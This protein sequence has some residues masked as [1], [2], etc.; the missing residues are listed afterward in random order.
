[1]TY[2]LLLYNVEIIKDALGSF[3]ETLHFDEA[4]LPH[5]A[6]H[7]FYKNMHAIGSE[8]PRAENATTFITKT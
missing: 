5:A 1:M 8:R 6:F 7:Q 2:V 4:W 3:I